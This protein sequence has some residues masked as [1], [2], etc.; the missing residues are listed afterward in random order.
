MS[1]KRWLYI[2]ASLLLITNLLASNGH[3]TVNE[4]IRFVNITNM[5]GLPNNTIYALC[6]DYKGFIWIGTVNGLCRYDGNNI[7]T[8]VS[9]EN[10]LLPNNR[11]RFIF[12]DNKYRLWISTLKGIRLYDRNSDTFLPVDDQQ[13]PYNSRTIHQAA[14]NTIY[15]GGG[16]RICFFDE[17]KKTFEQLK[18]NNKSINGDFNSIIS[19][20]DGFL[21]V[22]SEN[23][24][25]LCIDKKRNKLRHYKH[26]SESKGSLISNNIQSLYVDSKNRIWI[27]TQNKGVCYY[28]EQN[29]RFVPFDKIPTAY[30]RVISEDAYNNIWIGTEDGLYIYNQQTDDII[31]KKR[32]KGDRYSISDNTIY[33]LLKDREG[34]MLVGTYYGGISIAPNSFYQFKYYTWGDSPHLLSGRIVKQIVPDKV[35]GNLWILTKDGGV[36]YYNKNKQI[37]ERVSFLEPKNG[38]DKSNITSLLLDNKSNLFVGSYLGDLSKYNLPS[39]NRVFSVKIDSI[40]LNSI[41]HLLDDNN[42]TIWMGTKNGVVCYNIDNNIFSK[43][44]P[45]ILGRQWIDFMMK[46]SDNNIWI[47][48]RFV[49][50]Y[51]YNPRTKELTHFEHS[52]SEESIS[53]NFINYIF[54]DSEKNIWIGTQDGGLNKFNKRSKTFQHF[55][56]KDH[57]PSNTILSIQEDND[58]NIWIATDDGLS[59]YNRQENDFTNYSISEGLPNKQFSHNSVYKNYNGEIFLGTIDGMISFD[60]KK[61]NKLKN[62]ASVDLTGLRA[63]GKDIPIVDTN[64]VGNS[65]AIAN[66]VWTIKL[67]NDQAKSFS[68]KYTIPT[69]SHA[70]SIF[71]QMKF[72]E[73]EKWNNIGT[74]NQITFANLNPGEYNILLKASF[75]NRWTGNEP[76]SKIKLIIEPPF[77]LSLKAYCLYFIVFFLILAVLYKYFINKQEQRNLLLTERLEKEKMSEINNLRL[78]F[79]TNISHQLRL[80]LTVIISPLQTLI[81][82][83]KLDPEIEKKITSIARNAKRMKS[84]IDELLLFTKITTNKEKGHL[85][86]GDLLGFIYEICQEFQVLSDSRSNIMFKIEVPIV[87]EKV[88]FDAS[89]VEKIVYNL[90]TNAFKYTDEGIIKIK[91]DI[92]NKDGYLQLNLIVSDTGIGIEESMVEKIFENYYQVNNQKRNRASGFGIGLALTK[93][94]VLLHQGTIHVES[95]INIGSTFSVLLNVDKNAFAEDQ[96]F[97]TK[98]NDIRTVE[99]QLLLSTVVASANIEHISEVNNNLKNILVVDDNVELL[100]HYY[101]L[102]N[103][104]YNVFLANDGTKGYEMAINKLPDIII[105]DI[106]MP[107]MDGYEL[108]RQ[109]KS[110]ID[111][112]HIPIVLLTAKVGNEAKSNAYASGVELYIEKPFS[113]DILLAQISNLINLKESLRKKYVVNQVAIDEVVSDHKDQQLIE[114]IESYIKKNIDNDELSVNDIVNEVG[115][116][117][118]LL[119]VKLKAAVGL[120]ATQFITN[121][122]IK[123]SLAMLLLNR[124]ISEIAYNCG[125]SSANYYTRCFKKQ[126]GMSPS[127][128]REILVSKDRQ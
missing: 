80:P 40:P 72:E 74:E 33:S 98:A 97:E 39:G 7:I 26:N 10:N 45:E 44:K 104:K 121:V 18:V 49:G 70:S 25:I 110:R 122:R 59:C 111:T 31:V 87:G 30:V 100:N 28:D 126:F 107:T 61:L 65:Y 11:I 108:A 96:I 47:T 113:P 89:I 14:D 103:G 48:T 105:S 95:A 9:N 68:I 34:N 99:G 21:W 54:E 106:V 6:Q 3:G 50:L 91:A 120:S 35:K 109:L 85:T 81:E 66:K 75:N 88:C 73:E 60:P 37:F 29:D 71:Y 57:L 53:D 2:A 5:E 58:K 16:G 79:F 78:N 82:Q 19:D 123:E 63:L 52:I 46:D 27:G 23:N 42:G 83:K 67:T 101:E 24:G 76:T 84:L 124:N 22:G 90:L 125:F 119:Y 69:V 20:K 43:F 102:L 55:T 118:T 13:S 94:L 56:E 128:Y 114:K 12:E 32:D 1:I 17:G 15:F 116:S 86:E 77:W 92:C 117:R 8:Y 4:N 62:N 41:F 127:E 64:P 38:T 112:C 51:C 36:N 115:L 93:E